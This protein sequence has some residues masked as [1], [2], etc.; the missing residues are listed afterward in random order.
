MYQPLLLAQSDSSGTCVLQRS[1]ASTPPRKATTTPDSHHDVSP[2]Q[3]YSQGTASA[4]RILSSKRCCCTYRVQDTNLDTIVHLGSDG[5]NRDRPSPQHITIT[6]SSDAKAETGAAL[7]TVV[8]RTISSREGQ[9]NSN[10]SS[11]IYDIRLC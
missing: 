11:P 4:F 8:H 6:T 3:I 5:S 1:T 2:S 9:Y 7:L 10:N